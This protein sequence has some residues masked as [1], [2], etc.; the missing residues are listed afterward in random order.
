MEVWMST[1]FTVIHFGGIR[2]APRGDVTPPGSDRI[3]TLRGVVSRYA[4]LYE[5][6]PSYSPAS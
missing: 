3:A 6:R 2:D 1:R 5:L 4:I